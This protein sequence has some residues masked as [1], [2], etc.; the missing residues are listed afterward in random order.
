LDAKRVAV[1]GAGDMGHGIAELFAVNGY[2]VALMDKFPQ[3][4][5][6]AKVRVGA[7]L[8]KLVERSKLTKEQADAAGSRIAYS[9]DL[10]GAVARADLVVE[11]VPESLEMKKSVFKEITEHA[12]AN[13][14]L[15][16]NTSNIKISELATAT[17]R[18]E[19]MVGMHF[20]NPPMV[21][22]L[23]E[24][25]PGA[26]TDPAVVQEV[27]ELCGRIG[28]TP[29][30]V[31]KDS[32]G[33]IVNR[34]NA[35]D[36]L[37]FCLLLDRGIAKPD[38]V[39][40]YARS[41][42]L[43]MGP[44]ELLDFV[45]VD[46]GADS[47]A[48]FSGALSSEYGKG[49]TFAKM[50][51]EGLLGK[52][53]GRGFY[54]WS[55]G[56]AKIP[57]SEP[58]DKV[59]IMDIFALEINESVKLIEEGVALPEDIERGVVLGMNR[60]FGPIT[61]AKDLS[62]AE[63][64]SKLQELATKFDCQI[65]APARSIA[66]GRMRDAIEGRSAQR[67]EGMKTPQVSVAPKTTPSTA[68]AVR[69]EKLPGGVARVTINRPKFNTINGQ[70]LDELDRITTELTGDPEVR[71]VIITGEG[72]VFC[73]G[74]DLSQFFSDSVAFMNFARKGARI[75]RRLTEMP[76]LTMAVLKGYALGGG[77]ELAISCD[78][79]VATEDV[80]IGFPELTIGLV[81]AWSGSQRLPKLLGISQASFMILTSERIKGKRAFD[82]GL[83]NKL[84]PSGDPDEFAVHYANELASSQAPVAVMLAKKLLNKGGE[85]PMDDGLEMEAMAAGLLFATEDLREGISAFLGKRKAGFKGK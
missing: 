35:A 60:P 64:K 27:V 69:L 10:A 44:Y 33:F 38:E 43:P 28:R 49:K 2:N 66:E 25:I 48:Y 63:V 50:V 34:I 18:P 39:D 78:I 15:A 23:V 11:A 5:E 85:V 6:K 76:K 8:D 37:F 47:L 22:N 59:S 46:I 24:V 19:R 13:A 1:I 7:S 26:R 70:V 40:N 68:G 52:K 16:S 56:K 84:V 80:E 67:A 62:N 79:R 54:D 58:T 20:F 14:V 42:G 61:V 17:S 74:A 51:K 30:K 53:T 57:K 72:S 36:T 65:F 83:V 81:P 75:M 4:L 12:P 9:G 45:G 55:S 41:Q 82:I 71:A 3:A 31:L 73:A 21:M 29:V 32:P 77:L